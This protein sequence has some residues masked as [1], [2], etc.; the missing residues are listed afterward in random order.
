[1]NDNDASV[2]FPSMQPD[3][4]RTESEPVQAPNEPSVESVLYPSTQPKAQPTAPGTMATTAD[5]N[6]G[7]NP[8]GRE[9][10]R[11]RN[12]VPSE[13]QALRDGDSDRA[14]FSPQKTYESAIP[15][16]IFDAESVESELPPE[17]QAAVLYEYRELAADHGLSHTEI[18]RLH[19]RILA[20]RNDPAPPEQQQAQALQRLSEV[21]G[22]DVQEALADANRLLDRD[23]RTKNAIKAWG[24]GND[25]ETIVLVAQVARREKARGRLK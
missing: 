23:P 15:D 11:I 9:V 19:Q 18:G 22:P 3:A 13:V 2:L 24:L 25:P 16:D 5:P 6:A 20:Q 4:P 8:N 7:Q 21:Y 14:M 1:M 12:S 17:T 10:E